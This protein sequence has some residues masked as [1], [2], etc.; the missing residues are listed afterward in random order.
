MKKIFKYVPLIACA[1]ILSGCGN[2]NT[3]DDA[4]KTEET[5]KKKLLN[6]Y[7]DC[8]LNSPVKSVDIRTYKASSKFGELVKDDLAD[9]YYYIV[10]FNDLG[11]CEKYVSYDD[12][13]KIMYMQKASYDSNGLLTEVASYLDDGQLS[14]LYK[15]M[16]REDGECLKYEVFNEDGDLK[17]V[18]LR[19]FDGDK[20]VEYREEEYNA[21]DTLVNETIYKYNGDVLESCSRYMNK[22]L[23]YTEKYSKYDKYGI[24]ESS[25]YDYN[26]DLYQNRYFEYDKNGEIVVVRLLDVDG[27][28]TYDAECRRNENDLVSYQRVWDGEEETITEYEYEY[29]QKGNWIKKIEFKG[30]LR[31]PVK[32]TEREIVY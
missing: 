27:N 11:L 5:P 7:E 14:R 13:D 12:K 2:S 8:E 21:G 17:S 1:F 9:G 18:L 4:T 19:K 6:S 22:E 3:S 28:K 26:G 31:K 20:F 32:I 10:T 29:D 24:Q 23:Q 30:T 25:V 15:Y 16:C